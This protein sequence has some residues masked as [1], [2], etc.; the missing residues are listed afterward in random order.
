MALAVQEQIA[1]RAADQCQLI[2]LFGKQSTEFDG[3]GPH[4]EIQW[5]PSR[6]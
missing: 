2:T 4:F 3:L 5:A 1:D 6:M